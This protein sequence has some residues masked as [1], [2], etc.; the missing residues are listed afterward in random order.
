MYVFPLTALDPITKVW[1]EPMYQMVLRSIKGH[2]L[3]HPL[4]VHP[5]SVEEWKKELL[6]DKHQTPPPMDEEQLR[7]RVQV[8]CNRYFALKEL[9]F[10]AVECVVLDVLKEAQDLGHVL[11]VDKSWQRGDNLEVKKQA[12]EKRHGV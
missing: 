5:I 11:Y 8:G 7:L 4:V 6:L 2:G 12:K 10:T 1:E 9:G 3:F